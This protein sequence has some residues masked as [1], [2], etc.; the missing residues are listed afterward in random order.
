VNTER[1]KS[2]RKELKW[3]N[4]ESGIHLWLWSRNDKE[5]DKSD[6]NNRGFGYCNMIDSSHQPQHKTT[7]PN[8]TSFTK[9]TLSPIQRWAHPS[10]PTHTSL[11]TRITRG[12]PN[13]PAIY[14]MQ[15]TIT[16]RSPTPLSAV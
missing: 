8:F 4:A 9:P 1:S 2:L 6:P 11:S 12:T 13:M 5:K 15:P 14:S 3:L 10:P 7:I 16:V